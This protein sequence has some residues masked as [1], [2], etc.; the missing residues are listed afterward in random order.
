MDGSRRQPRMT[1]PPSSRYVAGFLPP[2]SAFSCSTAAPPS[3]ELTVT[4]LRRKHVS[5]DGVAGGE[6]ARV[7]CATSRSLVSLTGSEHGPN[8]CG[9]NSA[10]CPVS[11]AHA[12]RHRLL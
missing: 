7:L 3:A 6:Q 2:P 5:L 12:Q 9:R 1:A 10:S 4:H 8:M 11:R